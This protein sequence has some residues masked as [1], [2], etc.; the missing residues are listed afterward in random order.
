[1]SLFGDTHTHAGREKVSFVSCLYDDVLDVSAKWL[2]LVK[3]LS[4]RKMRYM[5]VFLALRSAKMNVVH[6]VAARGCGIR[7]ALVC[8]AQLYVC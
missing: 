7:M 3:V 5:C 6:Y 8:V 4:W 2:T 1:M